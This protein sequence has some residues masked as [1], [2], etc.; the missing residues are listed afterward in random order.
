MKL[1]EIHTYKEV[2]N[3]INKDKY[4]LLRE[5]VS[6]INNYIIHILVIMNVIINCYLLIENEKKSKTIEEIL[7]LKKRFDY[8]NNTSEN[9][10]PNNDKEM[11][12]L[13]Y[14]EID[15]DKIKSKIINFNLIS[16]LID[17][18]NELEIKLIY[19]EKEINI[20]KLL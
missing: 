8:K 19:M 3:N 13:Y 16:A 15:F 6:T 18:I 1:I 4:N 11:I 12:G 17:L 9:L 7:T 10:F 14:P 5:I 20:T 2:D